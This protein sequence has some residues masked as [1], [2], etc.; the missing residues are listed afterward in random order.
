[1][2]KSKHPSFFTYQKIYISENFH[3]C[4]MVN[5]DAKS[6]VAQLVGTS[7]MF[8]AETFIILIPPTPTIQF[9]Q[10]KKKIVDRRYE[11]H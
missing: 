3:C 8:S 2:V 11:N 6:F 5:R 7:L 10:K 4:N 9:S 1:M